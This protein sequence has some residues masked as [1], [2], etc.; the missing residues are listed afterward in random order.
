VWTRYQLP[1]ELQRWNLQAAMNAVSKTY[2]TI[3]PLGDAKLQQ[4][5]YTLF[6]AGFGY[7]ITPQLSADMLVTNLTD[8]K[9]Y[10][11][12]NTMQDG[13][14]WGDPRAATLTLRAKF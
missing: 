12:I 2:N 6:D 14:I 5:G 7:Q 3:T 8:K 9:Y 13:N 10:Q 1:G 11:R 4:G